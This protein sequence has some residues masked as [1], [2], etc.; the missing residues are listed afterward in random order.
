MHGK[1]ERVNERNAV[2]LSSASQFCSG[3]WQPF[4]KTAI[5]SLEL[6]KKLSHD[7]FIPFWPLEV[8][9]VGSNA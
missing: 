2:Y 9:I 4:C 8:S 6:N 7:S 1:E 5:Y 3:L